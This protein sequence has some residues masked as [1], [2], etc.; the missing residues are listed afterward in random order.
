MGDKPLFLGFSFRKTKIRETPLPK[1]YVFGL[2][3]V[4]SGT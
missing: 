3:N 4:D 2:T 1:K